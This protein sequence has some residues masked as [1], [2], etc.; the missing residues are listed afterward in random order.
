MNYKISWYCPKNTEKRKN[1]KIAALTKYL[2]RKTVIFNTHMTVPHVILFQACFMCLWNE[3]VLSPVSPHSSSSDWPIYIP[4]LCWKRGKNW[5]KQIL[6]LTWSLGEHQ[7]TAIVCLSFCLQGTAKLRM[8]FY[9]CS[10]WT[11][12]LMPLKSVAMAGAQHLWQP[13]HVLMWDLV[14]IQ[15]GSYSCFFYLCHI[16]WPSLQSA[17]VQMCALPWA[18]RGWNHCQQTVPG[19]RKGKRHRATQDGEIKRRK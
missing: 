18:E 19:V 11:W 16:N 14:I 6:R 10:L 4:R 3:K 1:I 8:F 13:G 2:S 12:G 15:K 7:G 5:Q 9:T 17:S